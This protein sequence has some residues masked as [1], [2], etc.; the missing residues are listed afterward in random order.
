MRAGRCGPVLIEAWASQ[1][2]HCAVDPTDQ[3]ATR[4]LRPKVTIHDDDRHYH[5][6]RD[7]R[8]ARGRRHPQGRP[9]RCRDRSSRVTTQAGSSGHQRGGGSLN[10]SSGPRTSP[11]PGSWG[12]E[13]TG[14]YG[15]GLTRYLRAAGETVHEVCRPGRRVPGTRQVRPIDAEMAARSVLAEQSLGVPKSTTTSSEVLRQ[16]RATRR[17][18]VKTRTL[19]ANLLPALLVTAPEDLRVD[20]DQGTLRK[21]MTRCARLP[22]A[23]P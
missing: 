3:P 4:S 21:K 18:A 13:G 14:S 10:C 2:H 16:L 20:L 15:A 5:G 7:Q 6:G 8:R 22:P 9:Y 1:A 11:T 17:S 23:G 12:L 19:A